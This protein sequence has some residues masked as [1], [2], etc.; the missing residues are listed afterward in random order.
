MKNKFQPVITGCNQIKLYVHTIQH[1]DYVFYQLLM[2]ISHQTYAQD[3]KN[4]YKL[5]NEL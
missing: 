2:E 1:Y 4:P 5:L 3:A